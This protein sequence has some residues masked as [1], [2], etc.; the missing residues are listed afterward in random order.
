MQGAISMPG[1]RAAGNVTSP[2][3]QVVAAA[4]SGVRSAAALNADRAEAGTRRSLAD[5]RRELTL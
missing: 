4:D 5:R 1:V 2:M 3:T